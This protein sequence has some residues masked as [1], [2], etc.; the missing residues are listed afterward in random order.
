MLFLSSFAAIM[1][2]LAY[3]KHLAS[4]PRL[5][6][7]AAYFGSLGL[8]LYFSIGVSRTRVQ[9]IAGASAKPFPASKHYSY[10]VCGA[11]PTGLPV[12]VSCE[13]LPDGFQRTS[14][15]QQLWRPPRSSLDDKLRNERSRGVRRPQQAAWHRFCRCTLCTLCKVVCFEK[16]NCDTMSLGEHLLEIIPLSHS[17]PG[18]FLHCVEPCHC[19]K[20]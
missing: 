15:C 6:F 3:L 19:G 7:T 10:H 11:Y 2:P 8:T 18:P 9:V 17:R 20:R 4:T 5:P 13:L 12:M 1:G 14:P 16:P